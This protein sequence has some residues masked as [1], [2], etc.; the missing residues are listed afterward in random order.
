MTAAEMEKRFH[1]YI[2]NKIG[3]EDVDRVRIVL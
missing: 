2:Q 1:N 3:D